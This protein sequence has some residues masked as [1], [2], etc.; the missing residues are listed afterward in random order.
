MNR[1]AG[2]LLALTCAMGVAA[3]VSASGSMPMAW[4]Q[5]F[6]AAGTRYGVNPLL[7]RA[8]ARQESSF[9]HDA[10]GKNTNGTRDLG[11]MQI[12]TWWLGTLRQAG[13]DET[14]LMDPCLNIHVGAWILANEIAR[15]GLTWTA[16]GAYHSPTDWRRA[17]YAVK[18]NRH[19]M[20]ELRALG[21]NVPESEPVQ[22][23]APREAPQERSA[24]DVSPA[25]DREPGVWEAL[26]KTDG[27]P[28]TSA[29]AGVDTFG[30]RVA[31]PPDSEGARSE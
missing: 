29:P 30:A 15:H 27:A 28:A 11:V 26:A 21:I 4:E 7:L 17:D 24:A 14:M 6:I 31:P 22:K 9:R 25:P 5:C 19:L 23:P 16:V 1:A 12:N 2:V 18:V 8:I 3:P 20:R 10:I 13:I